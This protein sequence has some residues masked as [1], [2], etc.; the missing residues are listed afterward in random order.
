MLKIGAVSYLNTRPLI[1]GLR[2]RLAGLGEL[3]LN[4]PSRLADDLKA[5]RL[6]VGLI[7][8]FEFLKLQ[9]QGFQIV[10]DA[11]IACHGPVWSV[12]LMSKVPIDQI[13]TLAIDEG[14]RTSAALTKVMLASHFSLFP[15]TVPLPIEQEPE[16]M[17]SDAVLVIGDRAMHPPLSVYEEIWDLG[18]RWCAWTGLPFVFAMWIAR[19]GLEQLSQVRAILEASRDAGCEHFDEIAQAEAGPHGLTTADLKR[20]FEQHLHFQ[21]GQR[22]L[23]G[24]NTFHLHAKRFG[25]LP[26]SPMAHASVATLNVTTNRST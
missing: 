25:I 24:L 16:S 22:E 5:G 26:G 10:S 18:E 14:S 1:Y 17:N 20:Y 21:L 6:D 4:L 12:R 11:V 7:P 9:D 8:S 15:Q 23:A 13:R 3:S 2:Q 19:P